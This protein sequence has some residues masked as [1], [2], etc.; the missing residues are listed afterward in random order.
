MGAFVGEVV[1]RGLRYDEDKRM[2][3][4]VDAGYYGTGVALL[5]YVA[6]NAREALS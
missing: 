4:A 3:V 1:A 5:L 2:R 6:A